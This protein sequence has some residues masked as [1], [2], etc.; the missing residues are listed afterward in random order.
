MKIEELADKLNDTTE[1]VNQQDKRITDLENKGDVIPEYPKIYIPDYTKEF[2]FLN[3]Q[4]EVF[5]RSD[6][7]Q[8]LDAAMKNLSSK[9]DSIPNQIKIKTTHEFGIKSLAAKLMGVLLIFT[10]ILVWWLAYSRSELSDENDGLQYDAANYYF[11][12]ALYP[13]VAK[14]IEFNSKT[15][16]KELKKTADSAFAAQ[17]TMISKGKQRKSNNGK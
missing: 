6:H 8:G 16:P 14:Y 15:H 1:V 4:L 3:K 12:K 10:Y 5:L 13:D 2:K 11:V 9:I 7:Q 17:G